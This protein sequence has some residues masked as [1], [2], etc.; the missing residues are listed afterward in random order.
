MRNALRRIGRD[1]IERRNIDAYVV[2]A[3]ALAF[4]V[5]D[6]FSG[7]VSDEMRWAVLLAGMSLLIFRVTLPAQRVDGSDFLYDRQHL[8]EVPLSERIERARTLWVLAP[9]AVNLLSPDTISALRTGMLSR[10]GSVVRILVLDPD[11]EHAVQIAEQQL[12]SSLRFPIQSL[13]P[14][15]RATLD[16]LRLMSGWHVTGSLEWRLL[17]LSPGFSLVAID[18]GERQGVLILE[19]HGYHG[20]SVSSRMHLELRREDDPRWHN[21]W[22]DQFE[23]LW[24]ASARPTGTPLP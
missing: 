20:D 2:S 10:R 5:F 14:S 7:A 13:R 17:D 21:Y 4:A 15:I 3:A 19:I 18:P 16:K 12:D 1:L 24:N 23:A 11:Q 22:A 6:L 9:S 8:A